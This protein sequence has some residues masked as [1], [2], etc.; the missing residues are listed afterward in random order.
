VLN[1]VTVTTIIIAVLGPRVFTSRHSVVSA[2]S[3]YRH[4]GQSS[5][6]FL[7]VLNPI[8]KSAKTRQDQ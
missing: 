1:L 2:T 6:N 8:H 5:N 7:C 4:H 3:N